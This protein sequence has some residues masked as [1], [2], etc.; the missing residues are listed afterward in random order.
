MTSPFLGALANAG[1]DIL[2]TGGTQSLIP[3]ISQMIQNMKSALSNTMQS[4]QNRLG[5]VR[6]AGTPFGQ[7]LLT[8]TQLQGESDIA[9]A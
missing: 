4:T 2:K 1:Q 9:K 7:R 5:Q 8:G 6:Q 3:F